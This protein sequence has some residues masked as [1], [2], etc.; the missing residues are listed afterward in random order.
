MKSASPATPQAELLCIEDNVALIA[1]LAALFPGKVTGVSN[2]K[3]G[4]E[5]IRQRNGQWPFIVL[6]LALPD[7]SLEATIKQIPAMKVLNPGVLVVMTGFLVDAAFILA[8]GADAVVSKADAGF[9][10]KLMA[11]LGVKQS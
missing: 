4:L 1:Y 8:Q 3:D 5:A 9:S 7:S 11:A 2:L 6:D 10:G